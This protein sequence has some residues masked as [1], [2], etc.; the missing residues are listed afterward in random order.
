MKKIL[1]PTI[2]AII[3]LLNINSALS[4]TINISGKIYDAEN[5]VPIEGCHVK[6]NPDNVTVISRSDGTFNKS[7]KAGVKSLYVSIIGYTSLNINLFC[8]HDTVINIELQNVTYQLKS[9]YVVEDI[10]R[11]IQFT[12]HG[13]I[14]IEPSAIKEFPHLFSEPDMMKSIQ[15][16]PGVNTGREGSSELFVRGGGSG[17]NVIL[18]NGC[19][20][21]QPDHLLGLVSTFDLDFI[22]RS[23]LIK[24]YFPS[25]LGGGASSIIKVDY[26][27]QKVDSFNIR[28]RLGLITSGI[29][30]S[31]P[32]RKLN[33]TISGGIKLS[34]YSFYSSLLKKTLNKEIVDFLPPDDYKF[35]DSYLR[36]FYEPPRLGNLSYL[37]LNSHDYGNQI[38]E[39]KNHNADT[40]KITRDELKIGWKSSVH[41]LEWNLPLRNN[42]KILYDININQLTYQRCISL[43][44][45]NYKNEDELISQEIK[46][47]EFSPVILNLGTSL[48]FN[49]KKIL[50]YTF[51]FSYRFRD[52]NQ[53]IIV[54]DFSNSSFI[55]NNL[56]SQENI[57]ESSIFINTEFPVSKVVGL[58]A[59]L[60]LSS[61][62]LSNDKFLILEPR[63]R[64]T[65]NLANNH[66]FHLNFNKL[67][68][69]DHSIESSSIGLRTIMWKPVTSKFGPE[70]SNIFSGG[71][72]GQP[73][74]K[75][76]YSIEGYYKMISGM[77]DFKPGASLLFNSSP[78]DLFDKVK[79]RSYGIETYLA[80]IKGKLSGNISYTYS[81]SLR[82]WESP[83]G[84]IWIS[85]GADRPHNFIL[86]AKYQVAKNT[87]FGFYW[88]YITG[89]PATLSLHSTIFG[90][91]FETKNNIRFPDYHR[92]DLSLRQTFNF[93]WFKMLIDIDIYNLYNRKNT[94]YLK[95]IQSDQTGTNIYK[96]ISL[97]PI[98]PTLSLTLNY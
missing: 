59:G 86:M 44:N 57:S 63:L 88:T 25:E 54:T 60:R 21:F 40:I 76:Q 30:S 42:N 73:R 61:A 84:L 20:F 6:I 97:F 52:F 26:K 92:L 39:Y 98:M 43:I 80:K 34:N 4:Q 50:N 67:S 55:E 74:K 87:K 71:F 85:S 81:R 45:E 91:W 38:A 75:F 64:L 72:I 77:V 32:I 51:G 93:K 5:K 49:H 95:R 36:I 65:F 48:V 17:Q 14:I 41:A 68:Q 78:E 69:F 82:E 19:Y 66:S 15:L 29:T 18:S 46:R 1:S 24:D 28:L 7:C 53:N 10:A 13:N 23:E 9:I 35:Y 79:G 16:L 70:I 58:D 22:D 8:K 94:F 33:L 96:N 11:S 89:L 3:F 83:S 31:I 62:F 56:T 37:F 12:K 90:Q 27:G 47:S 2:F